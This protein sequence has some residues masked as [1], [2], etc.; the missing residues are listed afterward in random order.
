MSQ[1]ETSDA[2][3]GDPAEGH[4]VVLFDGMCHLC[5]RS[6]LFVLKRDPHGQFHFAPL[7]SEFGTFLLEQYGLPTERLDS[8]VLIQGRKAHTESSAALRVASRLGF[9]WNLL[10]IFLIVPPFLRNAVYRC[11]AR[12]RYRWFGRRETCAVPRPEWK[13]RFHE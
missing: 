2:R 6:V 4:P 3:A 1:L 7:Q 8:M 11:I 13:N 9:P 5:D 12:N 10:G